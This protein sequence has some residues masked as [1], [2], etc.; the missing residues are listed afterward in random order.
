MNFARLGHPGAEIPAEPVAFM[1]DSSTL[2]GPHDDVL[3]SR[4]SMKTDWEVELAV[5]VGSTARYLDS[6]EVKQA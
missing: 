2:I 3:M 5:V 1:N 4:W 6:P